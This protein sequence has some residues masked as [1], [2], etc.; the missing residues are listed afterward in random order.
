[1]SKLSKNY[2]AF[3]F[4]IMLVG[5]G[6]CFVFGL[7]GISIKN[8]YFIYIPY[9]MGG[10]SP[11]IASYLAFRKE[12]GIKPFKEWLKNIFDFKHNVLSYLLVIIF[13]IMYILPQCIISGYDNGFPLYAIV[14]MIPALLFGGGLEEAGWRYILQPELEKKFNFTVSTL[15]VGIIWWIWH[16]PLFFIQGTSQYGTNYSGFG[17][18]V[19]GLSFSLAGIRKITGSVWLC[20][21]FHCIANALAGIYVV[22]YN[23]YGNIV[24]TIVLIIASYILVEMQKKKVIFK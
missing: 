10:L 24:T 12:G 13:G 3:T 23:L 21:L 18:T 8:N 14:I 17:I 6:I 7:N 9:L 15:I 5:W 1:M 22:K 19:L 11:T 4:L 20:V 16:L 2:L